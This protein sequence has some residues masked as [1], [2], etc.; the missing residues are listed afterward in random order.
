[1]SSTFQYQVQPN[2]PAIQVELYLPKKAALQGVLYETLTEG[3]PPR[4]GPCLL[5]R[6]EPAGEC[7]AE[8][9]RPGLVFFR[10]SQGCSQWRLQA[11]HQK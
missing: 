2:E 1:M 7:G 5:R 4:Q 10:F 6:P 9:P 3:F 8:G 11:F